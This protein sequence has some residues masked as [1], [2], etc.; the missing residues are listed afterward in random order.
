MVLTREILASPA[1]TDAWVTLKAAENVAR[2]MDMI[3]R[4]TPTV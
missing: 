1:L 3:M 2:R 4:Q